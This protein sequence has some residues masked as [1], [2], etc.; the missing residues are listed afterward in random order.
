VT[1]ALVG[2]LDRF[3][4]PG[5]DA[6]VFTGPAPEGLRRATFYKAWDEARA[7]VGQTDIHLS[8]TS[9]TPPAPSL[10]NRA[11]TSAS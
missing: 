1:A 11:Q 5:P 2:H 9:A 3:I 6:P 4:L 8:T 10:R 7:A